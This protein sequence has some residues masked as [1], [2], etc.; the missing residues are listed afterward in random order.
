MKT[1]YPKTTYLLIPKAEIDRPDII[2]RLDT[3]EWETAIQWFSTRKQLPR[4][5]LLQLF[6]V[7]TV[8][9]YDARNAAL[10]QVKKSRPESC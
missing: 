8:T 3:E 1:T 7:I 5:Q 6:E 9:E 10:N 4:K 2:D